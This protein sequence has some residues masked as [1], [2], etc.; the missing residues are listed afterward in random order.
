MALEFNKL[1]T[2]VERMGAM[3]RA[4]DFDMGARLEEVLAWWNA[5][6]D[7]DKAYE[8]IRIVRQSDISGY[9]GAAPLAPPAG[10]P[11]NFI[12]PAPDAPP[13]ATIVAADGSQ[14][15]PDE[16]S[17]VHYYVLNTGLYVYYHGADRVPDQIIEPQM[18]YHKSD[19]RDGANRVI[20]NRTVDARRTVREMQY[21][22]QVVW[23]LKRM[24][25]VEPL[26]AL[27]DNHLLFWV[28]S[29]ITGGAEI[30]AQ[31]RGA[32]NELHSSG[33][34]LAGYLDNPYRSRV[35]LRLLYLLSLSGEDE[36]RD[37]QDLVARGGDMEGLRDIHLMEAVLQ[38][39]ERTAVMVQNSPRNLSY[40]QYGDSYEVAFFYVKV[41]NGFQSAI[42]RVD[43]PM[44]VARDETLVSQLH[45][46][47][48]A[49]CQMQGRTPY[50][51]ALARADE[52]A[53]VSGRDKQKLDELVTME[54]RRR[55]LAPSI[56]SAK[57]QSKQAARSQKRGYEI[58]TELR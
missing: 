52:L 19:V 14:I 50:P 43:L 30:M 49:Q 44:W 51:Y 33:A 28:N 46:A 12:V 57:D 17:A 23:E 21:L 25:A 20:S 58:K 9:R 40:K 47:L 54:L 13:A 6:G 41:F 45:G 38:P 37:K 24:Q 2:Q 39:G 34:I 36:I 53:L 11:P 29:D 42:A 31:Y 1:M 3:I 7:L 5:A 35:V 27:Y 10:R 55:G 18:F 56:A 26:I 32:L 22:A 16:Q 48:L 4:V 8:Y 15:Y